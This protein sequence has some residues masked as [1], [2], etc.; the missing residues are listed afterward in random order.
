MWPAFSVAASQ[1]E[2]WAVSRSKSSK[3][4]LREHFDDPYV[5]QAQKAGYR[6][7]AVYKLIEIDER[8]ALLKPGMRIVELGAAPGG[9]TQYAVQRIGDHGF[10]VASDI[11]PMD[12][13]PNVTFVQGDFREEAV[14]NQILSALGGKQADLVISDMAPNMSGVD[15]VDQPRSMYLAELALELARQ[16]LKPGG[17]FL[18]KLFQGSGSEDYLRDL[19][20]DFGKLQMRKPKASRPRSREVYALARNLK[21]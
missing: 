9:W 15:A 20:A 1:S 17:D 4:W 19:R 5:L 16:V 14:L 11:L 10:V 6:S 2:R 18:T 21:L 7:R 13:F 12:S 3:R 8:D